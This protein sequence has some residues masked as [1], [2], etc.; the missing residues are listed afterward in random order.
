M[1]PVLKK[2]VAVNLNLNFMFQNCQLKYLKQ[3]CTQ[4]LYMPFSEY[5]MRPLL[6]TILKAIHYTFPFKVTLSKL[7]VCSSKFMFEDTTTHIIY[8]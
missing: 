2:V 7:Y 3:S 1:K 4:C 8:M 5:I 6:L